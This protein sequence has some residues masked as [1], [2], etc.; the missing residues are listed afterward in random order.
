MSV[1][2]R[3]LEGT[4][5]TDDNA[6]ILTM[7]SLIQFFCKLSSVWLPSGSLNVRTFQNEASLHALPL[8]GLAKEAET[9][10]SK[11]SDAVCSTA[12]FPQRK[13]G[14]THNDLIDLSWES[15]VDHSCSCYQRKIN[16]VLMQCNASTTSNCLGRNVHVE[17]VSLT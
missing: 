14:R 15:C 1:H 4:P 3:R 2:N 7:T 13:T 10:L 16:N 12:P 17:P 5:K 11:D 9:V 6:A 8:R